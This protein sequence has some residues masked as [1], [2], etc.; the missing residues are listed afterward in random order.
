MFAEVTDMQASFN[1]VNTAVE[2]QVSNG[3]QVLNALTSLRETTDQVRTGS[4]EI[5][6]ESDSIHKI[7]EN[8]KS[9]SRDVND[10]ILDVQKASQKIAESLEI[11]QKIAEGRYLVPPEDLPNHNQ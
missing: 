11:A 6:K 9:I 1:S 4:D 7:V 10:S 8:L 5:Q 2:A 3:A